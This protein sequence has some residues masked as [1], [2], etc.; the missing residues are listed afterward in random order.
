MEYL[1]FTSTILHH[2]GLI[3]RQHAFAQPMNTN[4]TATHNNTLWGQ[5]STFPPGLI[6][7]HCV[8]PRFY[9][10]QPM[11]RKRKRGG[12]PKPRQ[13]K[14]VTTGRSSDIYN[15]ESKVNKNNLITLH[16]SYE[17]KVSKDLRVGLLNA[18]RVTDSKI[19]IIED[20]ILDNSFDLFFMTETWLLP[21][22]DE[23]RV[24]ALTPS[25]HSTVSC[26]RL[27]GQVK[28][29]ASC[30]LRQFFITL[31]KVNPCHYKF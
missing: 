14:V 11:K 30:Y 10:Q 22:G 20:C 6:S 21:A 9:S 15:P 24:T 31:F 23:P 4:M 12:R 18:Q 16:N 25:S 2:A 13:I 1:V 27:T 28:A 8:Y 17:Q 3:S 5:R 19:N 7:G 26:P 29:A